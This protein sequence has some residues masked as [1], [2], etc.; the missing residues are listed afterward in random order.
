MLTSATNF[1][2]NSGNKAWDQPVIGRLAG[3]G[4]LKVQGPFGRLQVDRTVW[5]V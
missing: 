2:F 1:C 4:N 5:L 3:L